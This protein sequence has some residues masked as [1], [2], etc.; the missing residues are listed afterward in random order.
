[1]SD[2]YPGRFLGGSYKD[3][4]TAQPSP[5]SSDPKLNEL[6]EKAR[7]HKMTPKEIYEQKVSWIYGMQDLDKPGMSIEEIKAH[8]A[9]Q[10]IV[11]PG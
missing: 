2:Y 9:K 6:V 3:G 7:H 11:D 10:G 5:F 8:L 4:M 1:M